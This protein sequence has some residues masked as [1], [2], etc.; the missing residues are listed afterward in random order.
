ML[1]C[2]AVLPM[3]Q[4]LCGLAVAPD[5]GVLWAHLAQLHLDV[6][7]VSGWQPYAADVGLR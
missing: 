7:Q 5:S 2:A 1:T 3:P 4:L 6:L